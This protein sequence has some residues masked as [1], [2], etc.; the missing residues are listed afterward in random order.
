MNMKDRMLQLKFEILYNKNNIN[1]IYGSNYNKSGNYNL[2]LYKRNL[3]LKKIY[4]RISKIVKIY[5]R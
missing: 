5:E 1:N 2:E 4:K 3:Y